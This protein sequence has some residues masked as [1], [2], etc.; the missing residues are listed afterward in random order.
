MQYILIQYILVYLYM[1]HMTSWSAW[2]SW[3][4]WNADRCSFT[5]VHTHGRHPDS[6]A[7]WYAR[8]ISVSHCWMNCKRRNLPRMARAGF[9]RLSTWTIRMIF[10]RVT[11]QSALRTCCAKQSIRFISKGRAQIECGRRSL[12]PAS[13]LDRSLRLDRYPV[14]ISVSCI[15]LLIL[16]SH[17]S[18]SLFGYIQL[19]PIRLSAKLSNWSDILSEYFLL[20]VDGQTKVE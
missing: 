11:V 12:R 14:D 10:D 16:F 6:H 7:R 19:S 15:L 2:Y 8:E 3:W 13:Y 20:W 5:G 17:P 18:E 4:A 1:Q 9:C